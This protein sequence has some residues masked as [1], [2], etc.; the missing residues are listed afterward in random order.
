MKAVSERPDVIFHLAGVVSGEAEADFDK[1]YR[2]NLDG[3]RSLL[4][5]IRKPATATSPSLSS[6]PRSRCSARR[7]RDAIPDDF[8]LTPLTSYGAQKAMGELLLADYTR[9][10]LPRRRRHPPAHHR[11]CGPASRT[12]RRRDSSPASSASRW[13][14]RRRCCRCRERAAQAR[15]PARR[16]RFPVHAAALTRTSSGRASTSRCRASA[17][18]SATDRGAA[19]R[20]RRQ[21]RGAHPA[22]ARRL[23]MR[24]VAGWPHRF[25]AQRATRLGFWPRARSTRSSAR[26]SRRSGRVVRR[27]TMVLLVP[28]IPA[29]LIKRYKRFLADVTLPGAT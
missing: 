28:L 26:T 15:E 8:H 13:P 1:G 3:T 4:E 14:A 17:A 25:D 16:D 18:R 22:R 6:P 2:I 20:R 11:A 5:A 21:G 27:Q 9:Q 23:I 29:T 7:S 19:P 12:R 24:I 10:G